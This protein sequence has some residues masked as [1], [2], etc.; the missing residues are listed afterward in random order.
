MVSTETEVRA[1]PTSVPAIF[2]Q[3][4]F[5]R[6]PKILDEVQFAMILWE[7]DKKVRK[8]RD[9][10]FNKRLLGKKIGLIAKE[11]SSTTNNFPVGKCKLHVGRKMW[12]RIYG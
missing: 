11:T 9:H 6:A 7:L 2:S 5:Y 10:L 1:F 8:F 3:V 4:S 12:P